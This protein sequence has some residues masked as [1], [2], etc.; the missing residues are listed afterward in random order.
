ME[1]REGLA[2][3]VV[4]MMASMALSLS[5]TTV[6]ASPGVSD[7]S[8]STVRENAAV[9]LTITVTN[10]YGENIENIMIR[11]ENGAF[12]GPIGG[13]NVAEN[14]DNVADNLIKA[15]N[16]LGE[17]AENIRQA[18]VNIEAA[19][20][21]LITAA[22]ELV[23]AGDVLLDAKA[24]GADNIGD[25]G[26]VLKNYA[27]Q[28]MT[29][30][31]QQ[32][33]ADPLS[34]E[35]VW[36]NL[37]S[38]VSWAD[39]ASEN[40]LLTGATQ[41]LI[42][43]GEN[44]DNGIDNIENARDNLVGGCLRQAALRL[45]NAGLWFIQAGAALGD[46]PDNE[47]GKL[48][49]RTA[50]DKL[51]NKVAPK[52]RQAAENLKRAADNLDN[53]GYRLSLIESNYLENARNIMAAS[54]RSGPGNVLENNLLTDGFLEN[55]ENAAGALEAGVAENILRAG[56]NLADAAAKQTV[57]LGPALASNII[58]MHGES[59]QTTVR[60]W[61][62]VA[63]DNMK[64]NTNMSLTTTAS[65]LDNAATR[66][67]AAG[68]KLKETE[69]LLSPAI[70][71]GVETYTSNGMLLTALNT[72]N[73]IPDGGQKTFTFLWTA[74]DLA[75]V[76]EVY[77]FKIWL[78]DNDN[79]SLTDG[80]II[81][82]L[83]VDG[84]PPSLTVVVSQENAWENNVVGSV[85][86][87]GNVTITVIASESLKSIGKV[88][89]ENND[90][91]SSNENVLPE[92]SMSTTDNVIFTGTFTVQDTWSD[93]E[94]LRV[95]VVAPSATDLF[96]LENTDDVIDNFVF[97]NRK[98]FLEDNGLTVLEALPTDNQ[99]GTSNVY[100]KDNVAKWTIDGR[101]EDTIPS[102]D[103]VKWV[104]VYVNG[105][106]AGSLPDDNFTKTLTLSQGL[107]SVVVRVVDRVGNEIE[108]RIDNVFIDNVKP[109]VTL[110]QLANV[111]SKSE[112]VAADNYV[113]ID[114]TDNL[115]T[116]KA[117][118]TDPGYPSTGFGVPYENLVVRLVKDDGSSITP[119]ENLGAWDVS[120]GSFE[121][122]YKFEN[123]D[124]WYRLEIFAAD[125]INDNTIENIRFRIDTVKPSATTV[126]TSFAAAGHGILDP[127]TMERVGT[128]T[129]EDNWVFK[130][131][132][133]P[134][135]TVKI[136]DDN[137]L[138]CSGTADVNGDF[139][140]SVTGVSE[141]THVLYV[142]IIDQAGNE[143]TRELL[144][145]RIVDITKPTV[146]ISEPTTGTSTSS[147]SIVVSGTI[148]DTIAD[149]DEFLLLQVDSTGAHV[150]KTIY[151]EPD[152]SFSTSVPLD[153]GTNVINVIA[154]DQAGNQTISSVT[155]KRTVTP[156]TMYAMIAAIV[157]I[158]IAAIA[159]L[160]RR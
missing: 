134:K 69:N 150:A 74:P 68:N 138:L 118:I 136:W 55:I 13:E 141:G 11:D 48:D 159:V 93:N 10:D 116:I 98:P 35:N 130:A 61:I 133:E 18:A 153:E 72:D 44:L 66:L 22:S 86:D 104:R 128:T 41:T 87:N 6:T 36:D 107:N 37:A 3:I 31:G 111:T 123:A 1:Y 29:T 83:T 76:E 119:L 17:V 7:F 45:E 79:N 77:T 95:R 28:Y 26:T 140:I 14:W 88:W 100:Y 151:L 89:V 135:A 38:F 155:V 30:A 49:I 12:M 47:A 59:I 33:K 56:D 108:N 154:Q 99:P 113:H 142:Q 110:T 131:T 160:R 23:T 63:G 15:G 65:A 102:A 148:T 156:W 92:I 139:T 132:T 103:N 53:A 9:V 137:T 143:S 46:C 34:L 32:L 25:A 51:E 60:Y 20:D 158:V 125:N 91:A 50:G 146:T 106:L 84:E 144:G 43:A 157:A 127:V 62:G 64:D 120:T 90:I 115:L 97:D 78:M 126:V 109:T 58:G 71:W 16:E 5:T 54:S 8:P 70:G 82:A 80:G 42:N 101:A 85:Y 4:I 81:K 19:G 114:R 24:A 122:T 105:E 94:N 27:P 129:N 145:T 149:Y 21:A 152:G 67:V 73:H 39:K 75:D 96:D 52:L 40:L 124:N 57:W 112:L 117:T 121:N 147:S 2:A